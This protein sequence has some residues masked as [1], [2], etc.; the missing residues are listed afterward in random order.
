[1]GQFPDDWPQEGGSDSP[2]CAPGKLSG[3]RTSSTT[4]TLTWD[5]PYATCHLCPDA[6][7]FEVSGGGLPTIYVSHPPCLIQLNNH[8]RR[9]AYV[10]AQAA[11][12][13]FSRPSAY[14]F[15]PSPGMPGQLLASDFSDT[16][17][18]M[19]WKAPVDGAPAFDYLVSHN[20]EVIATVRETTWR[21]GSAATLTD[22]YAVR[23][24]SNA[25]NL[26]DL[27]V[28]DITPPEKP[29]GLFVVKL[30]SRAGILI[31]AKTH[32][33]VKVVGYDVFK[34][35]ALMHTTWGEVPAVELQGL[36]PEI[37]C[38]FTVQAFDASQNRSPVSDPFTVKTTWMGPPRNLRVIR[39]TAYLIEVAWE[40][41]DDAIGVLQFTCTA[42]NQKGSYQAID[43]IF[44]YTTFFA[45]R[46]GNTYTVTVSAVDAS[47][48]RSESACFKVTT[49]G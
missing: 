25:G 38:T 7:G 45:L 2:I 20:G 18:T 27:A 41:P 46:P 8:A 13:R 19:A 39:V 43:N 28:L 1:M 29:S 47:L 24:R 14:V 33:N 12:G 36:I 10:R 49:L 9:V 35:G 5:E 15:W 6:V 26:S 30:S 23:A 21:M 32:D 48:H 11:N 22:V 37:P 34:E 31:W 4:A 42:D 17:F 40:R 44:P 16:G 3:Y